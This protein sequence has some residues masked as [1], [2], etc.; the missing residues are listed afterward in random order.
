MHAPG[1]SGAALEVTSEEHLLVGFFATV[2]ASWS[3]MGYASA[4]HVK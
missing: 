1:H 3:G 2:V 4:H